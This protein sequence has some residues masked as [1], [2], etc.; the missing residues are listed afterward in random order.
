M[1]VIPAD[2]GSGSA[3][4]YTKPMARPAQ[5]TPSTF[6]PKVATDWIYSRLREHISIRY[7]TAGGK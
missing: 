6:P 5:L 7:S 4:I 3:G 2:Q 1:R